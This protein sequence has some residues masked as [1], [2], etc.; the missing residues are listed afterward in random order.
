ML[1]FVKAVTNLFGIS[2]RRPK[3]QGITIYS[4]GFSINYR[5]VSPRH[6]AHEF[7]TKKWL[8][9]INAVHNPRFVNLAAAKIVAILA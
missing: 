3:R 1:D 5:K 6:A 2:H 7:M 4:H 8:Q 9:V